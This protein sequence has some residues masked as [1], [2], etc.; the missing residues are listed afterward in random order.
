MECALIGSTVSHYRITKLLGRGGMGEV[1]RA[2]DEKLGRSVALKFLSEQ[3]T[4]REARVRFLREARAAASLQHLNICTVH[5]VGEHEGSSFIVMALVDGQ[6]LRSHIAVGPLSIQQSVDLAIQV[7][8]GLEFAPSQQ[9]VHRDIKPANIMIDDTGRATI[10]DFGLAKLIDAT[11]VTHSGAT[12]G[13]PWYMA[14]EQVRGSDVEAPAN[15]GVVDDLGLEL[16]DRNLAA[17]FAVVGPP[18]LALAAATEEALEFVLTVSRSLHYVPV[19][20]SQLGSSI[21]GRHRA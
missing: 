7:A 5:E 16:F 13:T 9:I 17:H 8:E 3:A 14:P 6:E 21:S 2:D 10:M 15:V 1:Y 11:A 18:D 19:P 4:S 12:M 20:A